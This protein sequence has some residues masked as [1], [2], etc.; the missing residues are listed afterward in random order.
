MKIVLERVARRDNYTIGRL[1]IDG[2]LICD[3]LEPADR[4]LSS[5]WSLERLA[6]EKVAW[7]PGKVAIPTGTYEVMMGWSNRFG[8]WL[9]KVE[10]VP[11]FTGI[12]IHAGNSADDTRGCILVGEN[13]KVGRVLRSKAT[14]EIVHDK[15]LTAKM[16]GEVVMLTV[17]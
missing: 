2:E 5:S 8:R 7:R 3:T 10:D 14:L 13:S 16:A 6:R 1:Y 11:C 4:G 9:P 12:F 17:R 15:I